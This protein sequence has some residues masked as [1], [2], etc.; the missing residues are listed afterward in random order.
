MKQGT[1]NYSNF[2]FRLIFKK[3]NSFIIP[4]VFFIFSVIM[5]IIFFVIKL[6]QKYN[7]ILGYTIIFITLLL[8][9]IYSSIKSLNIFK[10]VE[11][12]G[13]E[14]IVFSKVITRKNIIIGKLL[15]FF[16]FNLFWTTITTIGN[17]IFLLSIKYYSSIPLFILISFVTI[18]FSFTL[19]GMITSIIAYKI[20][21]KIAITVPILLFTP[22][23]LTG[24]FIASNS[25]PI[26]NNLAY[27]LNT[28]Y[29]N[30]HSNT[31]IDV[32]KFYLNNNKDEIYLIPNGFNKNKF[33][34]AQNAYLLQAFE[35]SKNSSNS[36]QT[37]SWLSLPYQMI[38][39]FN[40]DNID[41]FSL[42]SDKN[43][44]HLSN[45]IY[46]NGKESIS[47]NYKIDKNADN[48]KFTL[49]NNEHKYLVPSLLK[50]YSHFSPS[51]INT[52]IIYA[53]ENAENEE[54]VFPEDEFIYSNPN[55]LVGELKWD[56]MKPL[57]ENTDFNI[58]ANNLLNKFIKGSEN[59]LNQRNYS[60]IKN[61]LLN[62][63]HNEINNENSNLYKINAT[64]IALLDKNAVKLKLIKSEIERKIY[65]GVALIYYTYFNQHNNNFYILLQSLIHND[66]E[67][68]P[69]AINLNINGFNYK[70]GGFESWNTKS[71]VK[72]NKVVIRYELK[73]SENYL[74]QF[75]DEIFVI[76][77]D[78]KI[79]YKSIY[80]LIW[81]T[82]SA[83]LVVLN[84]IMYLRKDYK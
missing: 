14:I 23:A 60:E 71:V 72:D 46:Y 61:N 57:L 6:D 43:K 25:T 8:T 4:I 80:V 31:E 24:S 21:Q 63:I 53:R 42:L 52:N 54:I 49:N 59:N 30:H 35:Y 16:L 68:K 81:F 64:D 48:L 12:E 33:S 82:I 51:P 34:D 62:Y 3:K 11:E 15:T 84:S 29:K 47:Y 83:L 20:N 55:N 9:I 32:E 5:S 28:E 65:F 73:P 76:K 67:F 44:T 70:I 41:I 39:I 45:Y 58:L 22:L 2:L 7:P 26:N 66:N 36:W 78:K 75:I 56:I 50:N 27:Y 13:I 69:N 10:D 19:A 38:D 79:I 37:Y 40:E 77:R 1:I 74:F 17:L 18:F